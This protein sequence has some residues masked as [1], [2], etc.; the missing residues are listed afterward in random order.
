MKIFSVKRMGD[1]I[2]AVPNQRGNYQAPSKE[3]LEAVLNGEKK[4]LTSAM[5]LRV[6]RLG[7]SSWMPMSNVPRGHK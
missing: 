7:G 6:R 3:V 4:R 5:G 2:V 1:K